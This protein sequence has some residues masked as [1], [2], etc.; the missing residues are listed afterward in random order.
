MIIRARYKGRWVKARVRKNGLINFR[1]KLY[2]SPSLAGQ[3]AVKGVSCNGWKF[4]TYERSPGDWVLLE[5]LRR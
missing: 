5:T 1:G 3:D 4:W 2:T